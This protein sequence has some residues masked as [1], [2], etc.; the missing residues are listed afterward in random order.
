M[1]PKASGKGQ[2]KAVTKYTT[3]K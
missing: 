3:S 2:K 1:P